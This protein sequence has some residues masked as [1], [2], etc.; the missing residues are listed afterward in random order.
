MANLPSSHVDAVGT[1]TG[2]SV[3][4]WRFVIVLDAELLSVTVTSQLVHMFGSLLI[5]FLSRDER[6]LNEMDR[7]LIEGLFGPVVYRSWDEIDSTT[8][9]VAWLTAPSYP[10]D[11]PANQLERKRLFFW[12]NTVR[13]RR[14]VQAAQAIQQIDRRMLR[15]LGLDEPAEALLQTAEQIRSEG[16]HRRRERRTWQRALPIAAGLAATI[17]RRQS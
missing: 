9:T 1:I 10:A 4:D 13:N 3:I 14:I 2:R 6:Q 16:R 11:Q 8:V 7:A 12:Q 17:S 5:G 15:Q